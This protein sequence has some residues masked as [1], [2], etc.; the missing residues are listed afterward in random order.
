[1]SVYM[2]CVAS[3]VTW[4]M[5]GDASSTSSAVTFERENFVLIENV[6]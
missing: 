4:Q 2:E 1:M 3:M 5:E 6:S